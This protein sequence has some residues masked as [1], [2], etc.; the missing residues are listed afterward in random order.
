V[1]KVAMSQQDGFH[2]VWFQAEFAHQP[3]DEE[4][5]ADQTRINHHTGILSFQQVA[6]AH[7][8]ANGI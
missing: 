2:G 3:S 7:N 5:L 8:A 1:I 6:A 4:W